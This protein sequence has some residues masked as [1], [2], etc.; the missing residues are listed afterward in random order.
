[1]VSAAKELNFYLYFILLHFNVGD[2]MWPVA[3]LLERTALRPAHSPHSKLLTLSSPGSPSPSHL[4]LGA[5]A[6]VVW[7]LD[8]DL[9][10]Q[11]LLFLQPQSPHSSQIPCLASD[12]T[13]PMRKKQSGFESRLLTPGFPSGRVLL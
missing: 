12:Q 9:F 10:L 3:A 11:I 1:M 7:Q 5:S 6:P 2:L 13:V 8:L 4:C